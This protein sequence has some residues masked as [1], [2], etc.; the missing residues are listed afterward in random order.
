MSLIPNSRYVFSFQHTTPTGLVARDEQ[1]MGQLVSEIVKERRSGDGV[2]FADSAKNLSSPVDPDHMIRLT[3]KHEKLIIDENFVD[4]LIDLRANS[5]TGWVYA[6][7]LAWADN[8][9]IVQMFT[10][11]G[12]LLPASVDVQ[13]WSEDRTD[14]F[15]CSADATNIAMKCSGWDWSPAAEYSLDEEVFYYDIEQSVVGQFNA[16]VLKTSATNSG[17]S[18]QTLGR[19]PG[20]GV[21][22]LAA[23]GSC[24]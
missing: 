7:A 8:S 15:K 17:I 24:G 2:V 6:A 20:R 22:V 23:S 9:D 19:V 12:V 13:S 4:M 14:T 21:G 16:N 10:K 11:Q 18:V 3:E 5:S 1:G